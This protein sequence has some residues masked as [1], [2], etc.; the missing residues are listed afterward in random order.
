VGRIYRSDY[1]G[2]MW[3]EYTVLII[4]EKCVQNIPFNYNGDMWAEYTL[5]IIMKTCVQNIPF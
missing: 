3:A 2:D 1:N 4:M 5:L